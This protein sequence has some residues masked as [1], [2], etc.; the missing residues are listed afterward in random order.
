MI[1]TDYGVVCTS[2]EP[3]PIITLAFQHDSCPPPTYVER[4]EQKKTKQ[5]PGVL[6][7]SSGPMLMDGFIIHSGLSCTVLSDDGAQLPALWLL[8]KIDWA[9]ELIIP[10]PEACTNRFLQQKMWHAPRHWKRAGNE[11]KHSLPAGDVCEY[12][13]CFVL[14]CRFLSRST[15]HAL[16]WSTCVLGVRVTTV[17]RAPFCLGAH[18]HNPPSERVFSSPFVLSV[19][20]T[21]N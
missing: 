11:N 3:G 2:K 10:L 15:P 12:L 1:R 19:L 4:K 17:S 6:Y 20:M 8:P 21:G 16:C 5:N 18:Y 14:F 7:H 13:F 9:S